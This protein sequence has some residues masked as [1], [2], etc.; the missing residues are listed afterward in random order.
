MA[1]SLWK[2][3]VKNSNERKVNKMKMLYIGIDVSKHKHDC[4]ITNADGEVLADP[5][6]IQNSREGFE[7]L[8]RRIKSL[9][10]R[11]SGENTKV[12]LEATGHYSD[13]ITGFLRKNGLPPVILN[14]LQVKLYHKGES[15]RKTKTD[16]SD[17]RYIAGMLIAKDLKP[18]SQSSYHS[19]ELKSLTRHRHRMVWARSRFKVLYDR[20][21]SIVFPELEHFVK[22]PGSVTE[23]KLMLEFPTAK[24]IADCHLT[25]LSNLVETYSHGRHDREWTIK[26]KELAK[27]SIGSNSPAKALEMQQTIRQIISLSKEIDLIDAEIKT[28]VNDSGTSLMT[29]PGIGYTLAAIIMSEVGDVTRF[30]TPAKLQAF[31]GLEPTTYQSGQF[32]G[33]R[34]VMV[35]RGS[36]YLRW[37]LLQAAR[38]ASKHD[39]TFSEY[40]SRK[41][42]D[43]KHYN[44]AMGHVAKKLIRVIFKLMNTGEVYQAKIQT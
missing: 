5:F 38:I 32:I 11:P 19:E 21:R 2:I 4:F 22:C 29:I 12:G 30:A 43:G 28:L 20:L 34:D 7:E 14:P 23:L 35:K 42:A 36:T 33:Q 16:K 17:A 40:L 39:T 8:Y 44:S 37:A 3:S 18:H 6:T 27:N 31:A 41:V 25:R 9:M 10:P 26:L 24:A 1:N 13:N 15:L